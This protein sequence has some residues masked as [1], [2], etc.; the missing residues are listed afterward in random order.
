VLR[1]PWTSSPADNAPAPEYR[2]LYRR[3]E[4]RLTMIVPLRTGRGTIGAITVAFCLRQRTGRGPDVVF[5]QS[6]ADAWA[7]AI[8][9]ACRFDEACQA[10]LQ[11]DTVLSMVSHDLRG[12]LGAIR[13]IGSGLKRDLE[14]PAPL[15]R[16]SLVD[17]LT[18][19]DAS[20]QEMADQIDDLT[21]AARLRAGQPLLLHRQ[22]I[23]L[24]A[25]ARKLVAA[26]ERRTDRH[27]ILLES[28]LPELVGTWDLRRIERVVANLL[29]NA[30]KFTFDAGD[31]VVRVLVE[32]RAGAR[33][34]VLQVEDPGIGI[35][36]ADLPRVFSWFFRARNVVHQVDGTGIGLAGARQIVVQHGGT[37]E[38]DSEEGLGS[39]FRVYLPLD[40][41][42]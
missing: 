14:Q 34:A 22:P 28:S 6:V 24:V 12:P 18:Q 37:I 27:R 20:A 33:W 32:E 8:D 5:L 35:P 4:P 23:D 26:Y 2:D 3:L 13:M 31:I 30:I 38:V 42:N 29:S 1:D 41:P 19:I 17:A 40:S 15:R 21:D 39:T 9:H 36:A 10:I 16:M 7:S 11:R 25:L